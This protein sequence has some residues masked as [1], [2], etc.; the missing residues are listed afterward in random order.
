MEIVMKPHTV[1][2]ADVKTPPCPRRSRTTLLLAA[3]LTM[4]G[5]SSA[6]LQGLT[7]TSPPAASAPT[8]LRIAVAL[9]P[10]LQRNPAAF[11]AA[12]RLQ[13]AL[14]DRYRKEGLAVTVASNGLVEPSTGTV[15]VDISQV[16]AGSAAKRLLIGFGA[17]QSSLR[18]TTRFAVGDG[19]PSVMTFSTS[20]KSGRKPGLILPGGIAAA[21]GRVAGLAI[22]GGID[23]VVIGR[24][25]L[26]HEADRTAR[27]I[28]AQTKSFYRKE[29][30]GWPADRAKS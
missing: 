11:K 20:A 1:T 28:V 7:M 17:G 19:A 8:G 21:T 10:D 2:L 27:L 12:Q 13:A 6:K 15:H 16:E 26:G 30:W 5:C 24:G 22:G 14:I 25:S 9:A 4:S 3:A 18:A 23:L 29:G